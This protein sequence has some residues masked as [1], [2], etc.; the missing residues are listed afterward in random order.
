MHQVN[1]TPIEI[2]GPAVLPLALG[3]QAG[4]AQLIAV[5]LQHPPVQIMLRPGAALD[6]S[7]ARADLAYS[8]A[9][10]WLAAHHLSGRVTVEVELAVPNFM[11]LSSAASL[12]ATL[13][14]GLAHWYAQP[15]EDPRA[16]AAA[17]GLP[18]PELPL[19]QMAAEG[20]FWLYGLTE[21]HKPTLRRTIQHANRHAWAFV[22]VL[23]RLDPVPAPTFETEQLAVA[24]QAATQLVPEATARATTELVA[25]LD[26]DN[27]QRFGAALS[28][29]QSLYIAMPTTP[30]LSAWEAQVL[31]QLRASGAVACG[32]S[33]SGTALFGLLEGDRASISARHAL[34]QL[35]PPEQGRIMAAITDNA[36]VRWT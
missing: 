7:G 2:V 16:I 36:G 25:A 5:A 6:L 4:E 12:A 35:V 13:G 11:G 10:R 17:C 8:Y 32:R 15:P 26:A 3:W 9:A 33:L 24:C 18:A 30:P 23:P 28:H 22:L 21:G 29:L 34:R 1:N 14:R 27:L 20:G 31:A 19:A